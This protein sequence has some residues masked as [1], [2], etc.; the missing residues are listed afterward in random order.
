LVGESSIAAPGAAYS[1]VVLARNRSGRVT[2]AMPCGWWHQLVEARQRGWAHAELGEIE[3]DLP[4]CRAGAARAR[5]PCPVGRVETRTS[6][7]R[8]HRC[9]GA[10]RP[11]WGRRF[12]AMSSCAEDLD[13]GDQ[14]RVQLRDEAA[15]RRAEVPST[16]KRT[17]E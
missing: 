8:G 5:S 6:I 7:G 2:S 14:R 9:A 16:R 1:V 12:S 17:S 10:M 11:S 4:P 13:A 15:R 3:P